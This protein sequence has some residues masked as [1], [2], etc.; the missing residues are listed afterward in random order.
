MKK[1]RPTIEE[2]VKRFAV[3]KVSVSRWKKNPPPYSNVIDPTKKSIEA[4]KKI[5]NKIPIALFMNAP[6]V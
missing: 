1:E 6:S 3:G 5:P 2:G 4:L